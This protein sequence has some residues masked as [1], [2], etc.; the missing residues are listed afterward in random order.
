MYPLDHPLQE[1]LQLQT[2]VILLLPEASRGPWISRSVPNWLL[3]LGETL[4]VLDASE[5]GSAAI[6][7]TVNIIDKHDDRI[8]DEHRA[9][10]TDY[11]M[12]PAGSISV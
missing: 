9:L 1:P 3:G 10:Y 11:I 6:R 4:K 5:V 8:G 2:I 7:A 12:A